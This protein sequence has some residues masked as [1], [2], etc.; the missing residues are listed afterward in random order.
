MPGQAPSIAGVSLRE[1]RM[2]SKERIL[3]DRVIYTPSHFYKFLCKSR[4]RNP[5]ELNLTEEAWRWVLRDYGGHRQHAF[6]ERFRARPTRSKKRNRRADG[7][8]EQ[9]KEKKRRYRVSRR[10]IFL[11]Q[12]LGFIS[13]LHRLYRSEAAWVILC[14]EA[15]AMGVHS[16]AELGRRLRDHYHFLP[17][18]KRENFVDE[19][20][21]ESPRKLAEK[22]LAEHLKVT[23]CSIPCCS[24]LPNGL[25]PNQN[26]SQTSIICITLPNMN[27]RFVHAFAVH[28]K[29]KFRQIPS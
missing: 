4:K 24:P 10:G 8:Q 14:G 22:E 21:T 11:K 27:P 26:G 19:V 6:L 23:P 9:S 17:Q 25:N 16:S 15:K 28:E 1:R 13:I 20:L 5:G 7:N 2:S 18:T 3:G 29:S 12:P